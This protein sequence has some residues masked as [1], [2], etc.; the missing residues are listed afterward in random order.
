M[1]ARRLDLRHMAPPQPMLVILAEL[2]ALGAGEL[3][4]VLPH[5]PVP[6]YPA[7]EQRGWRHELLRDAPGECVLRL[8]RP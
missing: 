6:L 3:E 4:A 1:S 2:D 5:E 8:S 7:L